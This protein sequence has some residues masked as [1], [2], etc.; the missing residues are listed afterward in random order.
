[1]GEGGYLEQDERRRWTHVT[2]LNAK[3]R[4]IQNLLRGFSRESLFLESNSD[5][6]TCII[7]EVLSRLTHKP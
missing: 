2:I 4:K 5:I 6:I 1:M 7:I 3:Y